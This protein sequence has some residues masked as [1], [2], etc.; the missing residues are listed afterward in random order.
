[1]PKLGH[2]SLKNVVS[3]YIQDFSDSQDSDDLS[4]GFDE[5][6]EALIREYN[7]EL[8]KADMQDASIAE[9]LKKLSTTLNKLFCRNTDMFV[10]CMK[11]YNCSDAGTH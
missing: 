7:T 3:Q 1:M 11:T 5:L 9:R 10:K 6:K 2:F 4:I 8:F